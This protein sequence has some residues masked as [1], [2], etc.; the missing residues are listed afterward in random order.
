MRWAQRLKRVFDIEVETFARRGGQVAKKG[1]DFN[2][3]S[4]ALQLLQQELEEQV[5]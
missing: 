1:V 3:A 5:S 4:R 2:A